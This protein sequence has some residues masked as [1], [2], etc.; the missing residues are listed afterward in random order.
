MATDLHRFAFPTSVVFGA[1]ARREVANHLRSAGFNRPLVVT[2][3]GLAALPR[4]SDSDGKPNNSPLSVNQR[5]NTAPATPSAT[6][7]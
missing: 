4:L 5:G 1:G 2:D 3:R 7:P 6:K